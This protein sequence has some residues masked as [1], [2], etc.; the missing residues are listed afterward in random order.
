MFR[1]SF[2]YFLL[3]VRYVQNLKQMHAC[4]TA[5]GAKLP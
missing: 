2:V 3:Y 4:D 1:I 5:T